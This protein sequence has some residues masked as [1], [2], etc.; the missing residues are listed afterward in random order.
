MRE[1][2]QFD[3]TYSNDNYLSVFVGRCESQTLLFEYLEK[4]YDFL[5]DDYIG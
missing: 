4:D 2:K 3:Y 1:V 5:G